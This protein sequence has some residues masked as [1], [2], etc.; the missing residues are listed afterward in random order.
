MTE[1]RS[2]RTI[3]WRRIGE[4]E[5][6]QEERKGAGGVRGRRIIMATE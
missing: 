5:R 1:G 6:E 4:R 2:R 3:E